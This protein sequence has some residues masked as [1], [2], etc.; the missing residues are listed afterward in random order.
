MTIAD[1][2]KFLLVVQLDPPLK[3]TLKTGRFHIL[4]LDKSELWG[5]TV[6]EVSRKVWDLLTA[7]EGKMLSRIFEDPGRQT[8]C[9]MRALE[10]DT[11]INDASRPQ[12]LQMQWS[13]GRS[14]CLQD[15]ID[16]V[17]FQTWWE[18]WQRFESPELCLKVVTN[19][20]GA[21]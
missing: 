5:I 9:Q 19:W 8:E 10:L 21:Y 2:D 16:D 18:Y 6:E 13:G 12:K 15:M 14:V 1:S 17:E 20:K 7:I 11:W 4:S 3:E